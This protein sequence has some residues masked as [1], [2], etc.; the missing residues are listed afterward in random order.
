MIRRPTRSTIFPYTTL[1]RSKYR[2]DKFE[3][4][5]IS[6]DENKDAWLKGVK[7][8]QLPWLST[9]D[10]KNISQ[11]GFAITAVPTTYLIDPDGKILMKEVGFDA[12]G[13]GALEKKIVELF[14]VR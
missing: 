14:G 8:Q 9:L 12:S 3:I 6:I 7:E 4:Y 2:S 1:F 11:S 13:N 10:T 5:S